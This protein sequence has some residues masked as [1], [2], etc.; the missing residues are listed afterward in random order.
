M[1]TQGAAAVPA[2]LSFRDVLRLTVM[3]RVWYAQVV[4]LLGDF[5]ALFAVIS[6][7]SFRLHGT[8]AQV[9]GVQIAYM[10]PFALISPVAGV[11]VD[12]WPVKPTLVSSDLMRAALVCVLFVATSLW[13]I[14]LVL[15]ALSCVST[16]FGPAQSVT[17]R[18]H[19]PSHGLIAANALMQLAMMGVRIVGPAAAG[20]LVAA[21]GPDLCYSLDVVSFLASAS[22]IGSVAIVRPQASP[23][24][25]N[26]PSSGLRAVLHEMSE[27]S[28]FIFH[29]A[30]LSFVVLAMAAGLFTIGCFGPLIA[31]YVR[32]SLHAR[33]GIFGIV[34]AM[35]GVG[36]FVGTPLV[37]RASATLPNTT[38]VLGGL[39]GIGAGALI[40]GAVAM[41]PAALLGTFVLGFTF[42]GIIVPAQTLMQQETP[43]ALMGRISSTVMSIVFFAQLLGLVLSGILAQVLGIRLVFLLCAVLAWVLAGAGRW[44]LSVR[45]Q[46]P[47][48][49]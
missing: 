3:R 8:P 34:S 17:I 1:T 6:V 49:A 11:F 18:S 40:L 37:R 43:H 33:A 29:H 9:T 32:E 35:I 27:G 25:A 36:M 7:V 5:L 45:T 47:L 31:I 28:R 48:A 46:Q 38:L 19:V 16:F 21:V 41:I 13:Q 10:L 39:A 20:V 30:A 15:C 4:S 12:R 44:L 42:A 2:P 24:T 23:T 22:L 26:R 14:Y